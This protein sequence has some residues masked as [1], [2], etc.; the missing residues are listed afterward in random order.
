MQ[1]AYKLEKELQQ[2]SIAS[3]QADIKGLDKDFHRMQA[4]LTK[5]E[6]EVEKLGKERESLAKKLVVY[7]ERKQ[8]WRSNNE[9]LETYFTS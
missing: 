6:N 2:R 1:H 8:E 9:Q 7:D 4:Q 5:R 3:L